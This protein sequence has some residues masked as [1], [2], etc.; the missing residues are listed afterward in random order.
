MMANGMAHLPSGAGK[1]P[2][3]IITISGK[4]L[5][6]PPSKARSGAADVGLFAYVVKVL[7]WFE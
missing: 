1:I 4:S 5:P 6:Y 3:Q 7:L 2:S